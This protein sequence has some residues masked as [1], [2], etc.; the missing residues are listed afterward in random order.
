MMARH[1]GRR[2]RHTHRVGLVVG[3]AFLFIIAA[4]A[5][6]TGAGAATHSLAVTSS[7]WAQAKKALLVLSDMPKG[8]SSAKSIITGSYYGAGRSSSV[9][10]STNSTLASCIGDT[11]VFDQTPPSITSPQF[12][13]KDQSFRINDDV[14]VFPSA[15]NASQELGVFANPKTPECL[16]TIY[17]G[18]LGSKLLGPPPKG[19]TY[20]TQSVTGLNHGGFASQVAGFVVSLPFI[21]QGVTMRET[22]TYV[23]FIKG[24]LGQAISF[25]SI[26]VSFPA[27]IMRHVTSVARQRLLSGPSSS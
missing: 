5:A 12:Q 13:N 6:P 14:S 16:N 2:C 3:S 15:K 4:V 21:S 19:V 8:W 20:G 1:K 25:S 23:L 18:P 9:E 7:E 10:N 11:A 22:T 27:S 26:G 17:K 24:T